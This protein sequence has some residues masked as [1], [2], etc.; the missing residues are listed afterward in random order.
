MDR[1]ANSSS[2][3]GSCAMHLQDSHKID[4]I[5]NCGWPAINRS[6]NDFMY[7]EVTTTVYNCRCDRKVATVA[8]P[9]CDHC[10]LPL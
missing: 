6:C 3:G 2:H 5:I 10:T 1:L 9:L 4:I 7:A 8:M